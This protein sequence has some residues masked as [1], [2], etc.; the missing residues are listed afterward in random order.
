MVFSRTPKK[1]NVNQKIK[2]GS[3]YK[4]LNEWCNYYSI[5]LKAVWNRINNL[6]WDAKKA[7]TTPIILK[8]K[9]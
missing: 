4:T 1:Y 7:L 9:K 6:G 8:Y 5:N 3:K 2:I